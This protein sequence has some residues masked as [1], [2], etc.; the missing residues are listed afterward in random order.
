MYTA[1]DKSGNR[2][3]SGT[4]TLNITDEEPEDKY[5]APLFPDATNGVIDDE[6]IRLNNGTHIL[7]EPYSDMVSG[8]EVRLYVYLYDNNDV[9][10][11]S[12]YLDEVV[13]DADIVAGITKLIAAETLDEVSSGKICAHY[14]VVNSGAIKGTS[15]TACAIIKNVAPATNLNMLVT[16]DAPVYDANSFML[17]PFNRGVITGNPGDRVQVTVSGNAVFESNGLAE[18]IMHAGHHR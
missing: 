2:S 12:G 5:S 16:K 7:I 1:T 10:V 6:S 14:Q 13:N 3:E 8:D 9:Q 11:W 17:R 18:I 4:I 15:D